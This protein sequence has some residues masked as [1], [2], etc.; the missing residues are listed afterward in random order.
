MG[1][2]GNCVL[3]IPEEIILNVLCVS[4]YALPLLGCRVAVGLS[5]VL[6]LSAGL[7]TALYSPEDTREPRADLS[8]SYLYH[9][10]EGVSS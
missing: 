2:R 3:C 4:F 9:A 5:V 1:A 10:A 6:L 8:Y 7:R